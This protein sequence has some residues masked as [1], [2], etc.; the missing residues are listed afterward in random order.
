MRIRISEATY[1]EII[2]QLSYNAREKMGIIGS[3]GKNVIDRF[4]LDAEALSERYYCRL[5]VANVAA[6]FD[7]TSF[8]VGIV[9]GHPSGK[10][11]LSDADLVYARKM[12][13]AS[14]GLPFILMGIVSDD[15]LYLYWVN[16]SN[17]IPLDLLIV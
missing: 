11:E 3:S 17:V 16:G 7:A 2:K 4:I 1:K 10:Y 6:L 13:C 8:F 9:H 12:I 5:S 14:K 15:L